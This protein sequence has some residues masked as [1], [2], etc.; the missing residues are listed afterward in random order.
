MNTI[1]NMTFDEYRAVDAI[2][3][4]QLKVMDRSPLHFKHA[5][6]NPRKPSAA[7]LIGTAVHHAILEPDKF[8]TDYT[9]IP[10][11]PTRS[12][13]DKDAF[14]ARCI[15]IAGDR[16]TPEEAGTFNFGNEEGRSHFFTTLEKRGVTILKESDY[17]DV[18]AMRDSVMANTTAGWLAKADGGCEASAFWTDTHTGVQ[19]CARFDKH[20]ESQRFIVEIKTTVDAREH[21]FMRDSASYGYGLQ[22]A[23]YLWGAKEITGKAHTH[24][25]IAVENTAPFGVSVFV[26]DNA[27]LEHSYARNRQL[28]ARYAEC[29]KSGIWTG[30]PDK[31]VQVSLPKWELNKQ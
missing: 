13:A 7:M 6:D 1:E 19:C 29:R 21:E 4:S 10:D 11:M 20:I 18:V 26:L 14:A 2:H 5:L 25:T 16:I 12:K 3:I 23:W 17:K 8:K 28:L 9:T 31:A 30:Y 27:S 22:A 15:E 24:V